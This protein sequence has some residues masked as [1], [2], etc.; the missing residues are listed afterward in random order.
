M[1]N[2]AT[3]NSSA[4]APADY[5]A[6]SG[7]LTIAAGRLT[8]TLNV[9]IVGDT[10]D[11]PNETF[12]VN[13]SGPANA[14]ILNGQAV[15]TITDNDAAPAIAISN[16]TVTEGNSGTVNAVFNITISTVSGFPI[17]VAYA[18]ANASALAGQDYTA[19]SGTASIPAGATS[20]QVTVVVT[21]DLLDEPS[22][23]FQV[24]L[25]SP[26]NATIGDNQGIGTITDDDPT[27]SLRIN[28]VTI[29]EPAS[30]A[31]NAVFTVTLSAASGRM[32]TVNYATANVTAV[33]PGDYTATSGALSFAPGITSLQI[34]V[35]IRADGTTEATETFYVNLSGASAASIADARG[36][37]TI[38]N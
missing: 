15:G 12:F 21:S 8:G 26:T 7:T 2:F 23:T 17:S 29:T 19:V 18:T 9:P 3:A 4:L 28:D 25:S 24:N 13:L 20:T 22:E 34:L 11:E 35:P 14:T 16:V 5:T 31:V 38:S 32:V 27:P 6:T 1:V 10:R 33:A 36:V 37:G 30:G